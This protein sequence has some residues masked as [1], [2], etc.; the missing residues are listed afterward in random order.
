MYWSE[1]QCCPEVGVR[2]DR[3]MRPDQ[4]GLKWA[5]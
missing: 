1:G 2:L 5:L 4:G 3:G